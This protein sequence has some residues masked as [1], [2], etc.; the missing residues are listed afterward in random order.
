MSKLIDFFKKYHLIIFL[1]F[2]AGFLIILSQLIL[3]SDEVELIDITPTPKISPTPSEFYPTIPP[4][5][6]LPPEEAKEIG[7]SKEEFMKEILINFPLSP[8]LPYP[9]QNISI[10]YTDQLELEISKEGEFNDQEKEEILQWISDQ[11]VDPDTHQII[12]DER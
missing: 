5:D 2:L 12:W 3:P 8:Y 9:D 6:S 10:R 7:I 11:G 1:A 4:E